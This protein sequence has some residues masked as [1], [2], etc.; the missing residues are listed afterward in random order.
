MLV[1]SWNPRN[2]PFL[3]GGKIQEYYVSKVH[4]FLIRILALFF[5]VRLYRTLGLYEEPVS[6][7]GQVHRGRSVC[8]VFITG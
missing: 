8:F 7:P 2:D 5:S 6:P 3:L 1:N 4:V